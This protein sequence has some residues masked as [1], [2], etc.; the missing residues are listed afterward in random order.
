[1]KRYLE[2]PGPAEKRHQQ[3]QQ[4]R[5][6]QSHLEA[7]SGLPF[8]AGHGPRQQTEKERRDNGTD[9]HVNI[10]INNL[11]CKNNG[12]LQAHGGK[13]GGKK[14]IFL[15]FH[16]DEIEQ[17]EPCQAPDEVGRSGPVLGKPFPENKVHEF[18][19]KIGVDGFILAE[20][21]PELPN[22]FFRHVAMEKTINIGSQNPL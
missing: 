1:M 14:D 3:D 20:L 7:V 15:L 13:T 4:S 9:R 10:T 17:Q 11:E 16:E 6:R 19:V 22:S 18:R 21:F 8:R 2:P 12:H 5:L